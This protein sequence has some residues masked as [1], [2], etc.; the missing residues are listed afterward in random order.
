MVAL[1]VRLL[2]GPTAM[3]DIVAITVIHKYLLRLPEDLWRKIVECAHQNNRSANA[4]IIHR[5]RRSVDGY[6]R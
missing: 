3:R 5:L 1:V 4:E 2:I 6:Q